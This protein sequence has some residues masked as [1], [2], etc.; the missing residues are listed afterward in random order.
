[1]EKLRAKFEADAAEQKRRLDER[2]Q[3]LTAQAEALSRQKATITEQIEQTLAT[4]RKKLVAEQEKKAREA[5]S[6]ELADL[7]EQL[8][9]QSNKI[10][11]AQKTQLDLLK[12][13]REFDE[14][15]KGFELEK[16]HQI[17]AER[18][19]IRTEIQQAA[20]EQTRSL[21]EKLDAKDRL[22]TEARQAEL[23]LRKERTDF[24]EQK[25]AFELEVAR[26]AD[27]IRETVKK[28]KDDEFRL[29]EA[30]KNKQLEDMKRQ[31]DELKRKAEQG[32]QQIQ[33]EVLELDLE[34]DLCRC[35]VD[36]EIMPVA[37][38]IHGGD[39]L[40]HVRT[41]TRQ[42]CGTIIWESKRTKTWSDGW[43]TKVKD[44]QLAAKAQLSIIVSTAVPRDMPS[45]D[46][47]DNVWV[48]P[49]KYAMPLAAALRLSLIETA[50]AKR[51]IDGRHDKVELVYE[52]L[53]GSEFKG[54][55][56]AIVNAFMT[57]KDDL[58]TE[59]R[60]LNRAWNKRQKQLDRV[61]VNTTGMYG[62]LSGIIGHSLPAIDRLEFA[63]LTDGSENGHFPA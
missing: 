4:E 32:S 20:T 26:K 38:G 55:V 9:E 18:E 63:A 16:A 22:L 14:Q 12:Q 37:K 51:A 15:K 46:C 40:Q 53:A 56:S 60:V 45:F 52:Y 10:N 42:S 1:M 35:F 59:K 44:D 27:E 8:R 33:G 61:M 34:S 23:K 17:E 30:E 31:I 25:Q 2:E 47:R 21:Q 29:K 11:Q 24:E 48:T 36:D 19:L 5:V 41:P 58:E 62:D 39:V 54:R 28:E 49:P 6:L 3:T 50:A 57:M 7:Q 43:I 13:R